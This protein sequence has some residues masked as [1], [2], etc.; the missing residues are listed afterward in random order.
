MGN[1]IQE[2][3]DEADALHRRAQ[4]LKAEAKKLKDEAKRAERKRLQEEENRKIEEF[5][6]KLFAEEGVTTNPK[7]E[8]LW[9]HAWELGHAYGLEEVGS[10][11]SQLVDLIK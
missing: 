7:A 3:L 8:M 5:K 11:F 4:D 6:T 9:G 2:K 10:H 1:T